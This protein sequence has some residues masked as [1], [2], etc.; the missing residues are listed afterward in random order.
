[1]ATQL[2]H[3]QPLMH[4]SIAEAEDRIKKRVAQHTNQKIQT[5]HQHLDAFELWVV[6]CQ[7]PTIDLTTLQEVLSSLGANDD[8][9]LQIRGLSPRLHSSS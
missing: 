6:A 2:H 7:S 9:I 8:S 5:V 1:M 3:I 4:K